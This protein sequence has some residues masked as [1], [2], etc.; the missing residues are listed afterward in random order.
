MIYTTITKTVSAIISVM[1]L[2]P[3]IAFAQTAETIEPAAINAPETPVE[4][5]VPVIE[6][7][8]PDASSNETTAET[9][10]SEADAVQDTATSQETAASQE[11][12]TSQDLE[13]TSDPTSIATEDMEIIQVS[14]STSDEV[15]PPIEIVPEPAVEEVVPEIVIPEPE[16]LTVVAETLTPTQEEVVREII[17]LNKLNER[18]EPDYVI[19][20]SGKQ[21]PTKIA[22]GNAVEALSTT[23]DTQ[24]G[25]LN[26]SGTC[27]EK[28]YVV[29]VY[30]TAED[31]DAD[32]S[33]Y[34]VNR[35]YPCEGGSFTYKI[36]ELP[37]TIPNGTYYLLIGEQGAR[38]GWKPVTPMTEITINRTN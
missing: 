27:S 12:A 30:R 6:S 3:Y 7:S 13:E 1:M 11:T 14:T 21:V 22:P 19:A 16:P 24:S 25:M 8:T 4:I 35:A 32:P 10:V 20:L 31:Y 28:F 2:V 33:S 36:D 34:V 5:T 37:N 38:G 26:L 18:L 9:V 17:P 23:V 15:L 29:L